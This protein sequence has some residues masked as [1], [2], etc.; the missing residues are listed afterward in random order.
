[1]RRSASERDDEVCRM[2]TSLLIS[3]II[4]KTINLTFILHGI[5]NENHFNAP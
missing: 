2:E 5:A 3:K 4:L 1:M